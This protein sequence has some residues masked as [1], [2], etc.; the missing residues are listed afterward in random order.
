MSLVTAWRRCWRAWPD[1]Q[2]GGPG[3]VTTDV[4]T[5]QTPPALSGAADR[6]TVLKVD[7][8]DDVAV[9]ASVQQAVQALASLAPVKNATD[10]EL[11]DLFNVDVF[12]PFA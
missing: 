7:P 10:A 3:G 12:A 2:G 9:V 11:R 4:G 1:P 8:V 6:L 5:L